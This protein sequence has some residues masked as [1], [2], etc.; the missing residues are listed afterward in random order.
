MPDPG[1]VPSR[2][3]RGVCVH[4]FCRYVCYRPTLA[5]PDPVTSL[6]QN[7]SLC[8][9]Y[10]VKLQEYGAYHKFNMKDQGVYSRVVCGISPARILGFKPNQWIQIQ[11]LE[12]G[13]ISSTFKEEQAKQSL[14]VQVA[15]VD[16]AANVDQCEAMSRKEA[17]GFNVVTDGPHGCY[18]YGDRVYFNHGP[19]VQ[20]G[21]NSECFR[22][23][24]LALARLLSP[25]SPNLKATQRARAACPLN[26]TE[27]LFRLPGPGDSEYNG[28]K[29]AIVT[30]AT[31][32]YIHQAAEL[33]TSIRTIG[34][35][36]GHFVLV[37]RGP[38]LAAAI[39]LCAGALQ[40][41]DK[42]VHL[43]DVAHLLSRQGRLKQTPPSVCECHMNTCASQVTGAR[44]PHNVMPTNPR[45]PARTRAHPLRVTCS[46]ARRSLP[47]FSEV[48][49]QMGVALL[50]LRTKQQTD[51][52]LISAQIIQRCRTAAWKSTRQRHV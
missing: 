1:D 36:N 44:Q 38:K 15:K 27:L 49:S 34:Q 46:A 52:L 50:A 39:K 41:V 20:T 23:N 8:N 30:L 19:E 11:D 3:E 18:Q 51:C 32:G 45:A 17:V 26:D 35:F 4:E 12:E 9:R 16:E 43:V 2:I 24:R 37:H 25:A 13:R 21:H 14:A 29:Y 6:C 5:Y 48:L 10:N 31:E 47:P 22:W 40:F 28:S 7:I 33:L 42:R